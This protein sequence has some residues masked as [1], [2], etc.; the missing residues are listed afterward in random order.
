[1]IVEDD[2]KTAEFTHSDNFLDDCPNVL[3]VV[4]YKK[5]LVPFS[6]STAFSL[7]DKSQTIYVHDAHINFDFNPP[8]NEIYFSGTQRYKSFT[9][10]PIN[11]TKLT[12]Q[13]K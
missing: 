10:L 2:C 1:M 6:L 4:S 12:T 11:F 3:F 8:G 9:A 13:K 7:F 5:R